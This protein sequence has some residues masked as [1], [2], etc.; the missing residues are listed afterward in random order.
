MSFIK[1][2]GLLS[3]IL[4]L[5]ASYGAYAQTVRV[6]GTVSDAVGPVIGAVVLSGNANQ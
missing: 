3:G 1:R 2:F 5:V 4:I 6:K